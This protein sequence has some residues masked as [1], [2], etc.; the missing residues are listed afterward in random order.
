MLL[1]RIFGEASKFGSTD[2]PRRAIHMKPGYS[3]RIGVDPAALGPTV[4]NLDRACQVHDYCYDSHNLS[5]TSNFNL[6]L[7]PSQ[8]AALQKCNQS[9][10]DASRSVFGRNDGGKYVKFHFSHVLEGTCH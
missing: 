10:C 3:V 2:V 5:V 4:N 6:G 1:L 7:S 8:K 9:L